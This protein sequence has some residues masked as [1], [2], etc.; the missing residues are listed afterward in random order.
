MLF[1]GDE[2]S[3]TKKGNNNTYCQDN[4]L[5]WLDWDTDERRRKFLEFVRH[6]SRIWQEQPVLQRRKFFIGR[7]IRGSHAKDITFFEPSGQEMTDE[8]WNAGFMKC[9]GIRMAGDLMDEMDE[10]G[11]PIVGD[12]LLLLMNAHWE[13][14]P[15]TLPTTSHHQVWETLVDTRDPEMP[16]KVCRGGE[17][18][19]LFGRSLALLRTTLP[20]DAG[21]AASA[22]QVEVL[23]KDARR[24]KQE[25]G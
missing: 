23:R 9:M 20:Q 15:F 10:R 21:G 17:K 1:G 18:Y 22:V 2:L 8:H 11:D 4:E 6:C 3:H 25:L 12:T 19:D 24:A 7:P 16:L 14:I 13:Q 5:T